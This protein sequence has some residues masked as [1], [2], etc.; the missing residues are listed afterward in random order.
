[1]EVDSY[2]YPTLVETSKNYLTEDDV[3]ISRGVRP[4]TVRLLSEPGVNW[5]HGTIARGNVFRWFPSCNHETS[6][7]ELDEVRLALQAGE[8]RRRNRRI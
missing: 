5:G 8:A 2:T 7:W 4:E 1:M 3:L 6:L